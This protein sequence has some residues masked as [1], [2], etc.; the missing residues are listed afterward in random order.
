VTLFVCQGKGQRAKGKG[1]GRGQREEV[2]A[3]A[4]GS[5]CNLEGPVLLQKLIVWMRGQAGV[6]GSRGSAGAIF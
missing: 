2:L 3:G 4:G 5:G 6:G 1:K